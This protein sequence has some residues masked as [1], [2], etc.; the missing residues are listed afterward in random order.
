MPGLG[1]I[2]C[3]YGLHYTQGGRFTSDVDPKPD[4]DKQP[5]Q[6]MTFRAE[7]LEKLAQTARPG[8]AAMSADI[9]DGFYSIAVADPKLWQFRDH[10]GRLW[11][12]MALPMGQPSHRRGF[13]Y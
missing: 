7:G 4:R 6:E 3:L 2:P 5:R 12:F 13:I 1:G 10:L 11:C 8:D 9:K